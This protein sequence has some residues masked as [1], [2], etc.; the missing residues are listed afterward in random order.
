MRYILILFLFIFLFNLVYGSV[1][2]Y[3]PSSISL[4]PVSPP[5][6]LQSSDY[7]FSCI[8]LSRT[9]RG[10]VTYTD[11]E[12]LPSGWTSYGGTWS[13]V[14]SG[15]KGNALQGAD[16]NN[17]TGKASQYY[18]NTDLSS[19]A[20]LW[21]SVKTKLVNLL[22]KSG[23]YGISL[24]NS[25]KNS[26]Y[27]IEI[28]TKGNIVVRSY[29][30]SW[31]TLSSTS[32]QNYSSSNWYIIVVNYT[33]TSS[34]VN[35]YVWVYDVNG[36][37]VA[38]LTASS[39]NIFTPSYIGVD[40][41]DV[42]ALFDDFIISNTDPRIITISNLPGSG[43]VVEV[44]DNLNNLVSTA[45]STGSTVSVNIVS[46]I[47]VGTGY[48]GSFTIRYPN[49]FPCLGYNV[50]TSDAILGGDSYS[51]SYSF[52]TTNIGSNSTSAVISTYISGSSSSKSYVLTLK[53]YNNDVK[54]YYIRLILDTSSS[55]S[56]YLTLNITITTSP[57][58]M[59]D[60]IRVVSGSVIN[61]FSGWISLS[62][63]SYA[64]I[65]VSGYYT[66]SG[67]SSTLN[68]Y[69]EYCSLSNENG[70]CVFYPIQMVIKS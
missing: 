50:S 33:V 24:I 56:S 2:D 1:F 57:S 3:Y 32:I 23:Y 43:Y 8:G 26:M 6:I 52:A 29:T 37:Q 31:S 42:T 30:G 16:N 65:Y 18:Y 69:L 64:Y 13:I 61:K 41:N 60:P 67:Q 39:T 70:V 36:A 11:F 45:T 4:S 40:V 5:I 20:S 53:I 34:A 44:Y 14:S 59:A 27:T 38:S 47:V 58:A 12:A 66:S 15:Y 21:V 35:F 22:K 10:A 68:L 7:P 54:P 46:D 62:G 63:G 48:D 25:G 19:Y 28:D 49:G 9:Y 55:I 51:L 17:G